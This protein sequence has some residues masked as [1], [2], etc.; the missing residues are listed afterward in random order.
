MNEGWFGNVPGLSTTL[1]T[2]TW[3]STDRTGKL[4]TQLRVPNARPTMINRF[5]NKYLSCLK[6][7]DT[8]TQKPGEVWR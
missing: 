4:G 2:D 1:R 3:Y 5:K 6:T 7:T 8:R